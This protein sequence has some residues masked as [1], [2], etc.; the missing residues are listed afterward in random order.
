MSQLLGYRLIVE[1]IWER[2]RNGIQLPNPI[3]QTVRVLAK[4]TGRDPSKRSY[5]PGLQGAIQTIKVG[6]VLALD[7]YGVDDISGRPNGLPLDR[8]QVK[9]LCGVDVEPMFDGAWMMSIAYG[10]VPKRDE[11]NRRTKHNETIHQDIIAILG[12]EDLT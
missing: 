1:P 2:E 3:C 11:Y 10:K 12:G 9:R 7:R 8:E 4:G 5:R 6:D